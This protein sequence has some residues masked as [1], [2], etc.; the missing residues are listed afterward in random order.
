MTYSLDCFLSHVFTFEIQYARMV[1]QIIMPFLYIT[2]FL[3]CYLLAVKFKNI[4]YNRSVKTTTLIYMYIYLQPSLIGGFVQLISYR[5]ISG[6]RWVQSNVSQ[7]FDT[8]YHVRWMIEFCLPMLL[9]LAILIPIYFFQGLYNNSHQLDEKKVR[10]QWGYLYNEYTKTAYFWEVIKILQKEL[11]IIFLTYYDDSVIIKATIIS[12]I[13]GVYLELSLKYKP[14]NLNNLIQ[15]CTRI[16]MEINI[17]VQET[18]EI[19]RVQ[20][21]IDKIFKQNSLM[22][23]EI[24]ENKAIGIKIFEDITDMQSTKH[25]HLCEEIPQDESRDVKEILQIIG[26][27]YLFGLFVFPNQPRALMPWLQ[28][29]IR[30]EYNQFLI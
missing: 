7:R 27:V 28:K 8:P 30:S 25:K 22:E 4:T 13:I 24:N 17:G 12:L 14:Y 21:F 20:S 15:N 3:L 2:F 16:Q 1:W 19:P 23:Q 29:Q 26:A 18:V 5:E 6:Y 11:M 9:V 10:L